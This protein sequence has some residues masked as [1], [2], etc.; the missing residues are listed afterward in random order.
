M[1]YFGPGPIPELL[2]N[3]EQPSYLYIGA[4]QW[5]HCTLCN[6]V[7]TED[8]VRGS[9]HTR[10]KINFCYYGGDA[11]APPTSGPR[12][13]LGPPGPPCAFGARPPCAFSGPP[14]PPGPAGGPPGPPGPPPP[15]MPPASSGQAGPPGPS[16]A[17]G[18]PASAGPPGPWPGAPAPAP[19]TAVQALVPA[20]APPPVS[21]EQKIDQILGVMEMLAQQVHTLLRNEAKSQEE[22]LQRVVNFE[23]KQQKAQEELLRRFD[24]L[25]QKLK[26]SEPG[27]ATKN[28][29][30]SPK[31]SESDEGFQT[32]T[33][34]EWQGS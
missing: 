17:L 10:K 1:S 29:E 33:G 14:G 30:P 22:L 34:R 4:D 16:A 21:I 9:E 11:P 24:S 12:A 28:S 6:K 32:V 20:K 13:A 31:N 25:E 5:W 23:E 15:P 27:D 8:H 2:P 7:A 26:L 18:P 19:A 3:G